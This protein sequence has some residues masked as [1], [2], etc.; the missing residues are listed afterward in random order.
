MDC[1]RFEAFSGHCTDLSVHRKGTYINMSVLSVLGHYMPREG[2]YSLTIRKETAEK[3]QEQA[4]KQGLGLVEYFDT[5]VATTNIDKMIKEGVLQASFFYISNSL[6]DAQL[7]LERIQLIFRTPGLLSRYKE[8]LDKLTDPNEGIKKSVAAPPLSQEEFAQLDAH[9]RE[10]LLTEAKSLRQSTHE[11]KDLI[12]QEKV[13]GLWVDAISQIQLLLW[14]L[15]GRL[16]PKDWENLSKRKTTNQSKWMENLTLGGTLR[17]L[18]HALHDILNGS[19]QMKDLFPDDS[20][21]QR[22]YQAMKP[23][24]QS[25]RDFLEDKTLEGLRK[26]NKLT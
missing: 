18:D 9:E 25:I 11:V 2:Y 3:L 14:P 17:N 13:F 19:E 5:L 4:K 24:L 8:E 26:E 16:F 1:R 22:L 20:E 7:Y 10:R 15:F 21:V 12:F 6:L 23:F